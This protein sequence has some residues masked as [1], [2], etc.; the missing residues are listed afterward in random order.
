MVGHF[1]DQLSNFVVAFGAHVCYLESA[2]KE[3]PSRA[4]HVVTAVVLSVVPDEY[5]IA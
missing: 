4:A 3:V 5:Q 1:F 2:T